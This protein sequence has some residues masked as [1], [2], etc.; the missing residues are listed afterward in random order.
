MLSTKSKHDCYKQAS[1]S[2][3][4]CYKQALQDY[5][6]PKESHIYIVCIIQ[7]YIPY[8]RSLRR[9]LQSGGDAIYNNI[10]IFAIN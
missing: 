1:K 9:N 8:I 5:T 10:L 7:S 2:K 6:L 4:D 3:N